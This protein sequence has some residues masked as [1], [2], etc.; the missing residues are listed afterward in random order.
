MV[1]VNSTMMPLGTTAPDF[2]LPDTDGNTV[3]REDFAGNPLLVIF[4]CNHCPF[5]KHL[6]DALARKAADYQARGIGVVGIQ[7]NDVQNYPQD[8][9]EKMAEEKQTRGYTFAYLFDEDQSVALA[10]KAACTPDF[11]LFDADH[12]LYYRGQFDDSRPDQGPPTGDDLDAAVEAL[13]AKES[14]PEPQRPSAGCN[15]KWKPGNEPE[16]FGSITG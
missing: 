12:K 2:A 3:R 1:L 4:M 9:P 13:L 6:A 14:P 10:Y 16:Y 11:F 5:V 15:I 7:S 8:G